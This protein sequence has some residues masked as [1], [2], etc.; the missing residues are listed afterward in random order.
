M[1]TLVPFLIGCALVLAGCSGSDQGDVKKAEEAA[2][3]APKSV[4][5]LP[6]DMPPE[7]KR[8]AE[9]AMGQQQAMKQQMD[10]QAEAMKRAANQGR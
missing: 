6:A 10:A 9:A 4:D 3:R 7:A 1:K 8:G 5:Q 2:A